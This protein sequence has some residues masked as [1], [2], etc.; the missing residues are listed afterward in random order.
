MGSTSSDEFFNGKKT[1]NK[2]LMN[3]TS[4]KKSRSKSPKAEK[5]HSKKDRSCKRKSSDY[6][7]STTETDDDAFAKK[8]H[9]RVEK[10]HSH[11]LPVASSMMQEAH[12]DSSDDDLNIST[13]ANMMKKNSD[14]N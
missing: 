7:C 2:S 13:L 14:N 6:G 1:N 5:S 11:S 3:V 12:S 10:N 8:K 4:K 9:K